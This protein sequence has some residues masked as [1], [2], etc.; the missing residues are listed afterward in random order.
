MKKR[1]ERKPFKREYIPVIIAGVILLALLVAL[2][3]VILWRFNKSEIKADENPADIQEVLVD[4]ANYATNSSEF[5]SMVEKAKNIKVTYTMKDDFLKG[6]EYP[7]DWGEGE[8]EDPNAPVPHTEE[9]AV[10]DRYYEVTI[11]GVDAENIYIVANDTAGAFKD[12]VSYADPAD[13]ILVYRV[14]YV[15]NVNEITLE[16]REAK[17]SDEG[18]L[19]RKIKFKTPRYN[20]YYETE[21]CKTYPDNKYCSETTYEK[22][23]ATKFEKEA[24]RLY[25]RDGDTNYKKLRDNITSDKD[26]KKTDDK[27]KKQSIIDKVIDFAKKN[28]VVTIIIGVVIVLGVAATIIFTKKKKRSSIR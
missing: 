5:E 4:S 7:E 18:I 8:G 22:I 10:Y 1:K 11:S 13:G 3:W 21:F 19:L 20:Y 27:V 26:K 17:G 25:K 14:L 23:S 2:I 12:H 16:F 24:L 28:T 6:Y 9:F 15:I